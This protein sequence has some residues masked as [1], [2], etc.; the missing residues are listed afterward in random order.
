MWAGLWPNSWWQGVVS[1]SQGIYFPNFNFN[2]NGS[3]Y[4]GFSGWWLVHG[5]SHNPTVNVT[6]DMG[7]HHIKAGWQLRYS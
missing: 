2:G 6:H 7:K 1:P 3:A 5:R 4:T